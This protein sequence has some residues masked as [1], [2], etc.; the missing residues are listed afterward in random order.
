ML[1]IQP[2]PRR[3]GRGA[4]P[5][6]SICLLPLTASASLLQRRRVGLNTRAALKYRSDPLWNLDHLRSPLPST[7]ALSSLSRRPKLRCF[8]APE[9]PGEARRCGAHAQP[10]NQKRGRG[11]AFARRGRRHDKSAGVVLRFR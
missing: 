4:H 1:G 9:D 10:A 8:S 5:T 2:H 6:E 11:S 7:P 3:T